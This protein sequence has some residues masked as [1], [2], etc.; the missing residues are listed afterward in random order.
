MFLNILSELLSL[1]YSF[2]VQ[3]LVAEL[4]FCVHVRSQ[5]RK[6]FWV[7][8]IFLAA[9]MIALNYI[10]A[11]NK[12]VPQIFVWGNVIVIFALSLLIVSRCFNCNLL[13]TIFIGSASYAVQ[14]F[15]NKSI[16][17]MNITVFSYIPVGGWWDI[18]TGIIKIAVSCVVYFVFYKIF[19]KNVLR[20]GGFSGFENLQNGQVV[21]L[22]GITILVV[23]VISV[24]VSA[25]PS[26]K[27]LFHALYA[28]CCCVLLLCYQFGIFVNSEEKQRSVV[29]KKLLLLEREQRSLSKE[30]IEILNG[31]C[32]DLKHQINDIRKLVNNEILDKKLKEMYDAVVLYDSFVKTGNDALDVLL[33]EKSLYCEKYGI[34]FNCIA[35]GECV[36]FIDEED[37]YTLFGNALDNAIESV[38]Q[39]EE[40]FRFISLNIHK[41]GEMSVIH[42]ENY[43]ENGDKLVFVDGLPQTTKA[44]SLY[45]GLG[46]SNIKQVVEK[47]NGTM[48]ASVDG[49]IFF[50]NILLPIN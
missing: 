10:F 37:V 50:L 36:G 33:T 4:L 9:A 47:L 5:R 17:L 7:K 11:G 48:S 35:D 30:N 24:A 13:Q 3:L 20:N 29:S 22:S 43:C 40:S 34:R 31:K 14:H 42:I 39:V 49:K 23:F 45:H 44:D 12:K 32:H 28:Q 15:L 27:D 26:G 16:V 46:M 1:G 38:G 8:F 41:K 18:L 19:V 21:F 6:Y 25:T 2:P